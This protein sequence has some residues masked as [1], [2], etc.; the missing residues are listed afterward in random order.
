M[1]REAKFI[2][3]LET[4]ERAE[5]TRVECA[6]AY[7]SAHAAALTAS[8]AKAD[9]ARKAAA[10]GATSELRGKRDRAELTATVAHHRLIFYRG[11][12]GERGAA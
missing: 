3:A 10:D 2:E 12:A 4:W 11:S 7:R 6:E 9:T 8:D 1:D 5:E